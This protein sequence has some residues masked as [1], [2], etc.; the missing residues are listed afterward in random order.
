VPVIPL[1]QVATY[2]ECHRCRGQFDLNVLQWNPNASSPPAVA[3]APGIIP[4]PPNPYMPPVRGIASSMPGVTITQQSN[5][6][7]TASMVLGIIGLVTSF[8][9]CPAV[10]MIPLSI[11]FGFIG[12]ANAAK[13]RSGKGKAIAGLVCS[14]LGIVV[15][16]LLMINAKDSAKNAPPQTVLEAAKSRVNAQRT[17]TGFGNTAESQAMAKSL[18]QQ[19]QTVHDATIVVTS[20][21]KSKDQYV[22]HCELH[23]KTCAFLIFVP[24]YRHFD[25]EAKEAM[26]ELAWS[27]ASAT[28]SKIDSLNESD[29][30]LCVGMK[31]LVLYGSI[32]TG[33]VADDSP[34]TTSSDDDE[35]ARFFLEKKAEAAADPI[36][37]E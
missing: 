9:I 14:L 31:G 22:V 2:I 32:M 8:L 16:T 12:L 19:M 35:L 28:A 37:P 29:A 30:E 23:E 20:G 7:A 36:E 3:M 17:V 5:G 10:V 18:A 21:N 26:N 15:V 34:K 33:S 4:P 6:M 13:L 1:N 24:D 11:I 25:D 27:L